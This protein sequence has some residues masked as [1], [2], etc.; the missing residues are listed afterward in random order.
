MLVFII[1][2]L[3]EWNRSDCNCGRRDLITNHSR[4]PQ[5][6]SFEK[7]RPDGCTPLIS[8]IKDDNLPEDRNVVAHFVGAKALEFASGV[9]E[10]EAGQ[11]GLLAGLCWHQP[12]E[13]PA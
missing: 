13:S 5:N 8:L 4:M 12:D 1:Y 6:I 3:G 9:H 7:G 2:L 10:S 11:E